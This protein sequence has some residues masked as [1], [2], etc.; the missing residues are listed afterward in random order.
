MSNGVA[1]RNI[2]ARAVG[3]T[4]RTDD[5]PRYLRALNRY[6]DVAGPCAVSK[7]YDAQQSSSGSLTASGVFPTI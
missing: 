7:R 1:D 4:Y 5:H 2:A 3:G 6:R